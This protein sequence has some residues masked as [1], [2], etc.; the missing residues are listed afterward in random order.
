MD[1]FKWTY[2]GTTYD[3]NNSYMKIKKELHRYFDD[4]MI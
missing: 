2:N 4:F 3:K 1:Y